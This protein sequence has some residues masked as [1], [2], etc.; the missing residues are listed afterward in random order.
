MKRRSVSFFL[1]FIM[2]FSLLGMIPVMASPSAVDIGITIRDFKA[3]YRLFENAISEQTGLVQNRLGVD[4]KPVFAS[5]T[6]ATIPAAGWQNWIG[7]GTDASDAPI[8]LAE[9]H[10][11]FNDAPGVNM[12]TTQKLRMTKNAEG[13]YAFGEDDMTFFPIDNQLFG[14]E[15]R[16]NNFHFTM[17]F[18]ES[19]QYQGVETFTFTGDDDVWIFIDNTLVVDL[20][21]V[22]GAESAEISLPQL[23][24][25]GVLNLKVGESFNFD[26]FYMER[27]TAQ[28]NL[29]MKTNIDMS[30]Y[31]NASAWATLD[32]D[33]ALTLGLLTNTIKDNMVGPIT[34]EEFAEVAVRFYE[35][36]TGLTAVA[37]PDNTF[38]DTTNPF[39][40]KAFNLKIV[41]GVGSGK[42]KPTMILNREQMAKMIVNSLR[43]VVSNLNEDVASVPDFADQKDIASWAANEARFMSKYNIT[44]GIGSNK[45]GPKGDCQRQ[46]AVAF[47]VRAYD[48]IPS[49]K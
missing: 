34:R 14:N 23:V 49:L 35:K 10:N 46:Q 2:L 11:L 29:S 40:L 37:A 9:L 28:S 15:G 25:S 30:K 7:N 1:V 44:K 41:A 31:A 33:K 12:T 13:L 47:L 42:F 26:M 8:T 18:H 20:G 32:L 24:S 17:E 3:D 19:F 4:R 36:A 39:V 5:T 22:H 16:D 21:G 48:L 38:S 27:H 45:Y 6:D 43:A